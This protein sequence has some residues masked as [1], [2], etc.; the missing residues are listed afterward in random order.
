MRPKAEALGYLVVAHSRSCAGGGGPRRSCWQR[1]A[2]PARRW[3]R[4]RGWGTR[5][6]GGLEFG[7]DG[8][9]EGLLGGFVLGFGEVGAVDGDEEQM[10]VF[11]DVEGGGVAG[12]GDEEGVAAEAGDG[13]EFAGGEHGVAEGFVVDAGVVEGEVD[14][15]LALGVGPGAVGGAVGGGA[16][17][18]FAEGRG[19]DGFDLGGAEKRARCGELG[20]Q[21]LGE[22]E[23]GEGGEGEDGWDEGE[24][25]GRAWGHGWALWEG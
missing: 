13:D 15:G 7:E 19:E 20:V 1:L 22:G 18:A 24:E 6:L 9:G 10:L 11:E 4:G 2:H 5:G 14:A 3:N 21:G 17:F 23:G 25:A 16:G 8:G 12:G